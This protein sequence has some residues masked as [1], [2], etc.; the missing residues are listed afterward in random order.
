MSLHYRAWQS[1]YLSSAFTCICPSWTSAFLNTHGQSCGQSSGWGLISALATAFFWKKLHLVNPIM[2]SAFLMMVIAMV[3]TH[4]VNLSEY[5]A[6]CLIILSLKLC[7]TV[8]QSSWAPADNASQIFLFLLSWPKRRM[9]A[10]NCRCQM[11]NYLLTSLGCNNFYSHSHNS[12]QLFC[13]PLSISN[14]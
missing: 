4:S 8:S 2:T 9:Q 10:P 14:N 11:S 6:L 3:L 13:L 12:L 1:F 5:I 7:S